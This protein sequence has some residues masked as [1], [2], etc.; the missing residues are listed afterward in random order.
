MNEYIPE[1]LSREKLER[2]LGETTG[3]FA[4]RCD[5]AAKMLWRDAARDREYR[6]RRLLSSRRMADFANALK[7]F[8]RTTP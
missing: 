2:W 8:D 4:E 1:D 5:H 3:E 6:E 7:H